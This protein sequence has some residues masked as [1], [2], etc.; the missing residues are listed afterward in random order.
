MT[1]N[2]VPLGCAA[3]ACPP[4]EWRT[5]PLIGA[6]NAELEAAARAA[7]IGFIDNRDIIGPVW[8]S[9]EDWNH[10]DGRPFEAMAAAVIRACSLEGPAHGTSSRREARASRGRL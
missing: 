8:D 5:P 3:L 10:P 2:D 9:A 4:A 7:Q 6:Y 1:T